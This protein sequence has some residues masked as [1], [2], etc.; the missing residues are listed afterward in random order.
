MADA[1][2][3]MLRDEFGTG[4]VL[5]PEMIVGGNGASEL[6]LSIVQMLRPKKVL[7][8]APSF[9]GYRHALSALK[10]SATGP[11]NRKDIE[12]ELI[13]SDYLVKEE[14]DFELTDD[15][16]DEI[17][18]DTDLVI[19]AN[20]NNPTGR[21]ISK[22]VLEGIIRKCREAGAALLVDECF[23]H[24][25]DAKVSALNYIKEYTA[26]LAGAPQGASDNG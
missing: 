6:L 8:P 16:A 14:N 15:F 13:V 22:A 5:T 25:S 10:N 12:E 20:P 2:N 21:C 9:Y 1:E 17:R 18:S 23:L 3:Y 7:L 26:S 19:L 11:F 4:D 24:L